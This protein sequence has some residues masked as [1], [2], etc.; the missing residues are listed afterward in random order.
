MEV[1]GAGPSVSGLADSSVHH[2]PPLL[3]FLL[4]E[5]SVKEKK[6]G[7]GGCWG[8]RKKQECGVPRGGDYVRDA[9]FR[10]SWAA[11]YNLG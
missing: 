11:S 4:L 2:H 5:P 6:G 3:I 1:E 8:E 7:E 9:A 10:L